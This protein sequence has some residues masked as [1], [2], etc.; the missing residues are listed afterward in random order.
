MRLKRTIPC[1]CA[2]CGAPFLSAPTVRLQKFCG[3]ACYNR[4]RGNLPLTNV[5][6]HCT[7]VGECWEWNGG[8]HRAGYGLVT[9]DGLTRL[10]HR[11]A[12]E[13][14]LGF[15]IPEG[16]HSLHTCDNRA[17]V[18]N[19]DPGIYVIRGI[20][21]PR[22][23]HLFMGTQ[24]DNITDMIE[25]GRKAPLLHTVGTLNGRAKLTDDQ[26]IEMRRRFDCGEATGL[27]LSHEYHVSQTAAARLL[28][29]ES[30]RHLP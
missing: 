16:F 21:R 4:M 5:L 22:Y 14:A 10:A 23:G 24:A 15:P 20:A 12:L 19:D 11:A 1:I 17:C 25:K 9:Y 29:R 18:R 27:Q 3:R 26:V 2:A 30:W 6:P 7:V 13:L 28:R 8:Q